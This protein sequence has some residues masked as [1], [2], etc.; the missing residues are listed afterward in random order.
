MYWYAIQVMTGKETQVA[1]DLKD[2]GKSC[3][4]KGNNSVRMLS[5]Q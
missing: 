5:V 3:S 1:A 4:Q 2:H